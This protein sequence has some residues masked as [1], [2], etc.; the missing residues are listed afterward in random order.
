[1]NSRA[2]EHTSSRASKERRCLIAVE[3][4]GAFPTVR[5]AEGQ[6]QRR[7]FLRLG[8]R[9]HVTEARPDPTREDRGYVRTSQGCPRKSAAAQHKTST[10][11]TRST[12][13]SR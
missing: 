6:R 7:S 11:T 4:E 13:A 3:P 9:E 10:S 8:E 2:G 5:D 1:M 12:A